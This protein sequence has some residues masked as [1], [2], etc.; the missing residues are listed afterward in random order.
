MI[1]SEEDV[2]SIKDCPNLISKY[3]TP[4]IF[5]YQTDNAVHVRIM[6]SNVEKYRISVDSDTFKFTTV[7]DAIPY[8]LGLKLCGT[9]IA[10]KTSHLMLGREVKV[11]F[12]KAHKWTDWPRLQLSRVRN[13]LI[14][15]DPDHVVKKDWNNPYASFDERETFSEYRKRMGI[16]NVPPP[17]STDEDSDSDDEKVQAYDL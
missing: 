1:V 2:E 14:I 4:K 9:V 17:E 5:W 10:E 16:S 11:C 8:F 7:V 3:R 13:P 15:V 6:L 12:I